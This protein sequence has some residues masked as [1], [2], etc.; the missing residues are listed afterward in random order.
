MY[1][2]QFNLSKLTN[3]NVQIYVS[4]AMWITGE[5]SLINIRSA[6][7]EWQ[8][9]LCI[10]FQERQFEQDYIEFTYEGGYV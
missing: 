7:Q 9:K 2:H 4:I 6:I 8:N 5:M 3:V 1:E 10:T